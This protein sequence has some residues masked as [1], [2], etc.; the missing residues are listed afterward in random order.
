MRVKSDR[1][2]VIDWLWRYGVPLMAGAI[3]LTNALIAMRKHKQGLRAEDCEGAKKF[4]TGSSDLDMDF[5]IENVILRERPSVTFN[6][7]GGLDEVK[8]LLRMEVI[9]PRTKK[10]LYAL[11]GKR[12][13]CGILLYGPPGCGKTLIAKALANECGPGVEFVAPRISDVMSRYVGDSE[14]IIAAIFDYAK[15][16]KEC[17]IFFDEIDSLIPRSGPSYVRRVKNTFLECVDGITSKKEGL[18]IVGATNAPWLIDPAA[19]R[20][21]RFDKVIYVPPPDFEARR[22]IFQIH[23]REVIANNMLGEDVDIDE[24]AL[25]TEGYT[26]ADIRA[27]CEEA[28]EAALKRALSEG[29]AKPITM[30]DFVSAI[31][32]RTPSVLPWIIEAVRSIKRYKAYEFYEAIRKDLERM[33]KLKNFTDVL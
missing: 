4:S 29:V 23:L 7:I 33:S 16:L 10:N 6:D 32:R 31:K 17:V 13:G 2:D 22:S 25:L 5:R 3:I 18:L 19:R 30:Q 24:L 27:V 11:Y 20:P 26:G 21:G 28:K 15:K 9:Y 12:P 1:D 14:K 8:E